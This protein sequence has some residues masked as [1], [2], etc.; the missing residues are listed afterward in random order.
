MAA[1]FQKYERHRRRRLHRLGQRI[2]GH[3]LGHELGSTPR[4][5][6]VRYLPGL[7]PLSLAEIPIAPGTHTPAGNGKLCFGDH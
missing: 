1:N 6:A 2:G 3:G 5:N 4:A 7:E